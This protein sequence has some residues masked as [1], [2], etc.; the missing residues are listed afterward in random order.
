MDFFKLKKIESMY[1]LLAELLVL[2]I[3]GLLHPEEELP[4]RRLELQDEHAASRALRDLLELDVIL[5]K[6]FKFILINRKHF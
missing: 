4:G 2:V 3:L 5:K 6:R 1:H